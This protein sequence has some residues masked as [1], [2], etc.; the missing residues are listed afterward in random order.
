MRKCFLM[1]AVLGSLVPAVA[2][3]Q[4]SGLM[5]YGPRV[6][7]SVGPDQLVLGGHVTIGEVAQNVT[8]DPSFDL[9]FGDNVTTFGFNFDLHYHFEIRETNWRPYAG[10]GVGIYFYEHDRAGF[11]RDDSHTEVGGSLVLG[12]MIPTASSSNFFGE[13]KLGLGSVPDLK[14]LVGWSFR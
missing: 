12:S 9:G 7:F 4:S 10:A 14:M 11:V 1:F 5:G 3:A 6:G 2:L 13:F 8:F